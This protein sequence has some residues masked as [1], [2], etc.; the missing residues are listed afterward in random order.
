M[1]DNRETRVGNG[2][3]EFF[4]GQLDPVIAHLHRTTDEIVGCRTA[5]AE[6]PP[7]ERRF[8]TDP[9]PPSP[10]V[11]HASHRSKSTGTR[12][13][14]LLIEAGKDFNDGKWHCA[15]K[16]RDWNVTPSRGDGEVKSVAIERQHRQCPRLK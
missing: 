8:W 16:R 6:R 15:E 2:R 11:E 4:G 1:G 5:I 14:P 3:P 12:T 9:T 10:Q 7:G 13:A